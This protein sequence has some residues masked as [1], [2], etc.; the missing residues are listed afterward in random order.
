MMFVMVRSA[1]V[2][3]WCRS[4]AAVAISSPAAVEYA[5]SKRGVVAGALTVAENGHDAAGD[6]EQ[7]VGSLF[8]CPEGEISRSRDCSPLVRVIWAAHADRRK[9]GRRQVPP[10]GE[11]R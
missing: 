3:G 8:H 6:V 4:K 2:R 11:I 7:P 10:P 1:P 5:A 9:R